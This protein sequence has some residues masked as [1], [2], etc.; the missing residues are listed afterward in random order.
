MIITDLPRIVPL[1]EEGISLNKTHL[2]NVQ[3][4]S[5]TWSVDEDLEFLEV[6]N[7]NLILVSD[8]IYYEASVKRL[9]QTLRNLCD[10]QFKKWK[11]SVKILLAYEVRDYL[12]S[13]QVI[14][15]KFFRAVSEVFQIR[16]FST[17]DCHE[18]YASDDIK[19]IQLFPKDHAQW[20][21]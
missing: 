2:S 19:V 12:E 3:A 4:R 11:K 15:K 14:A 8:C 10:Y 20:S 17:A 9:I 21:K 5:L 7:L 18:E 13:K 1:L 16:P 6:E